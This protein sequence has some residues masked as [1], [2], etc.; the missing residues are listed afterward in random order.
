L[1]LSNKRYLTFSA[2]T[3]IVVSVIVVVI[4]VA[5]LVVYVSLPQGSTPATGSTSSSS[6]ASI[7]TSTGSLPSETSEISTYAS[8]SLSS[9]LTSSSTTSL[10]ESSNGNW[11][12][13]HYDLSRDGFYPVG[14]NITS[15]HVAWKSPALDG[16]VYAEPLYANGRV[17]IATENNSVYALNASSGQIIWR[18]E[19]G[20]PVVSSTLPCGDIS[21]TSGIT[22]TPVIDLTNSMIYVVAF[23]SPG[24][25]DLFGLD[26]SSGT[27][28]IQKTVDPPSSAQSAIDIQQR[29]ALALNGDYLYIPYGG[30]TGDCATYHGWIVG[31]NLNDTAQMNYYEVPC[32]NK[33]GIWASSGVAINSQGD[34]FVSTGNSDNATT[35]DYG[36]AVIELSPTLSFMAYFAPTNWANLNS[37]DVDLGS[38]GPLL[39]GD[40]L[41]FQVGKQGVGYLLNESNLGGIGGEIYSGQVCPSGGLAFG[42]VAYSY[43]FIYVAC[44]TGLV[45]LSLSNTSES[46]SIS[47]AD[48]SIFAS[49]PILAGGALW[50][51]NRSNS[52]L[53]AYSPTKGGLLY[54][55]GLGSVVH[56]E[57]PGA[58]PGSVLAVGGNQLYCIALV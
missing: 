48:Q 4:I 38:V 37:G 6:E 15:P 11:T 2:I 17:Y 54:N 7:S 19:L 10:A 39:L 44:S 36:E 41:V 18:Q 55:L 13:Y 56:F 33:C 22:G 1:H 30:L 28:H 16:Q 51:I 52:T 29:G 34:L 8:T 42:G 20:A 31:I 24:V 40:S 9:T 45:A 57:T 12:T 32:G 27:V 43:P 23:L 49:P 47:W 53:Y 58:F 26:L 35:F 25:H 21:P 14:P 50:T 46:F 3:R 5:G